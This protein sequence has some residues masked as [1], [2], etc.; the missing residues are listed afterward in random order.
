[1]RAREH[2]RPLL[3]QRQSPGVVQHAGRERL[4]QMAAPG[5]RQHLRQ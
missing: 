5:P 3:R 1:M 2:V 4:V